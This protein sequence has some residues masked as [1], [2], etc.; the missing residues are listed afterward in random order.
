MPDE[1][2]EFFM[3]MKELAPSL[4]NVTMSFHGHNDLGLGVAN[5]L[6]AIRAG[7][8]QVEC[9]VNG[10]GER[11]GN[12]ALEEIVMALHVRKDYYGAETK[13]NTQ[14]I[15]RTSNALSRITGVKVQPNKAIVGE[16][17]FAHESGIHQ[18]GVLANAETYEIMTPESIGLKDNNLVLGKH[19]GKHAFRDRLESLGYELSDDDL[20]VA[21]TKFK[22]LA[23]KKKQV[24]DK[25]IEAIVAKE[26]VQVPKTY[27]LDNFVINSGVNITSTAIVRLNKDGK[28]YERVS[29]GNGPLDAAFNC[30]DKVTGIDLKLDG[31]TIDAVT[32]GEDSMG[33]A[34]VIVRTKEGER[35]S[36]RGLSTDVNEAS[37][38]AYINAVNK[39]FYERRND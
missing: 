18:H 35:Y 9:T 36:G 20:A 34:T 39:L 33:D 5:A 27:T 30:V 15:T 3:N 17:A 13:I 31:L 25:D 37:I 4:L 1:H 21:F 23:D 7:V 28:S 8:N 16:N 6:A 14:E 22:E 11:A 29:K 24:Y 38:F 19:S 2:Y 26:S 10:I 12:A 32:E